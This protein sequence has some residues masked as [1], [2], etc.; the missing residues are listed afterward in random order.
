MT[1]LPTEIALFTAS[2]AWATQVVRAVPPFAWDGPGLG[3]WNLRALVGHTSRAMLTVEQYLAS[4]A[5]EEAVASAGEYYERV[6]ELSGADDAAVLQ[7]GIAAGELL[8][9][10]PAAEFSAIADRVTGLLKGVEAE[11]D[12]LISTIAG[13]IR[14][15]RYLPTRTF[16]LIVHGLDIARAVGSDAEPPTPC[17]ARA[18]ELSIDLALRTGRGSDLLM[19]LT[20]RTS[21]G[22]SVLP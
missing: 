18:L 21:S 1:E 15:S 3:G 5:S 13:G 9:D 17:L 6:A 10:T 8:G 11:Q 20:G 12:P 7:R 22:F 14:L 4:R 16:E 2:A 19:L